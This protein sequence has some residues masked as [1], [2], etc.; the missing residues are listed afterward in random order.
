MEYESVYGDNSAHLLAAVSVIP[1]PAAVSPRRAT[2]TL[3]LLWNLSTRSC[4][5]FG[6]NSKPHCIGEHT[7][8]LK[9]HTAQEKK[10]VLQ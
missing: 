6:C 4:L 10:T 1:I 3:G 7:S 8:I 5:S 9:Q 2:L